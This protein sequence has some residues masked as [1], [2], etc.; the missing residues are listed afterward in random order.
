MGILSS[1]KAGHMGDGIVK[2]D[3]CYKVLRMAKINN[4]PLFASV[5]KK[6][7]L[8]RTYSNCNSWI[9]K[10]KFMAIMDRLHIFS[11]P[12]CVGSFFQE[13]LKSKPRALRIE[14]AKGKY[15]TKLIAQRAQLYPKKRLRTFLSGFFW[16]L[17]GNLW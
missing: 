16:M 12:N 1:K 15:D 3:E 6:E 9:K 2:I 8:Y 5:G 10:Q 14:E 11:E 4:M 17:G 7:I 13:N